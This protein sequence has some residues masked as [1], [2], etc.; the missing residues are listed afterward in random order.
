MEQYLYFGSLGLHERQYQVPNFIGLA[1]NP[2]HDR[3]M[4]HDL[5]APRRRTCW[6]TCRWTKSLLCWTK[7][8]A[9]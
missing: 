8:T 4:A 3:E 9:C 7:F 2:A 1:L 5:I 6:S